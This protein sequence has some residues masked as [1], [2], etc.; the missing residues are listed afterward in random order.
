[1]EI[2][3]LI[4]GG[5]IG[6][7]DDKAFLSHGA[8]LRLGTDVNAPLTRIH[9]G[10]ID[11]F[12]PTIILGT[13]K[14]WSLVQQEAKEEVGALLLLPL[15]DIDKPFLAKVTIHFLFCT[16]LYFVIRQG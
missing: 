5:V 16:R 13:P 2:G 15:F 7:S 4:H 8:V 10:G 11:V 14:T 6:F 12:S 3:M 9:A 1:M